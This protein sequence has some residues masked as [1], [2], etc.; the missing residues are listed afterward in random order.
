MFRRIKSAL[1]I[2]GLTLTLGLGVMLPASVQA[3]AT[4]TGI[5]VVD[6]QRVERNSKAWGTLQAQINTRREGFQTEMRAI[7]K[8]IEQAR[9]ALEQRRSVVTPEAFQKEVQAFQVKLQEARQ[10]FAERQRELQGAY[11]TARQDI[12]KVI[13]EVLLELAKERSFG[14]ILN[15][16]TSDLTVMFADGSILITDE[17][18]KRLDQRLAS[19]KLPATK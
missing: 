5:A 8:E 2:S 19:V 11:E 6:T 1:V 13:G 14:L 3:Q 12:R 15:Q 7:E 16:G 9:S 17:V 10:T 18:L 4:A